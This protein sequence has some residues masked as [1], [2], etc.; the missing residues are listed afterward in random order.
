[1]KD[2]LKDVVSAS[3]TLLEIVGNIMDISKIESDKMEIIEV[4]YNFKEEINSLAK[5]NRARIG[6]KPIEY[7][8]NIAED[9]PYELIG[10]KGYVKPPYGVKL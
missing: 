5:I 8:I 4:P 6:N 9:V 1:M 10:D 7:T 3:K 2:D